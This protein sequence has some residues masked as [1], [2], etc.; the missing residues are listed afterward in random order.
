M[1]KKIKIK[2][3]TYKIV[4]RA[5]EEGIRM[6]WNR[7]HKYVDNPSSGAIQDSIENEIMLALSEVITWPEM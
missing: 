6:G 4:L 5:V 2:I 7:S 1:A 3:D